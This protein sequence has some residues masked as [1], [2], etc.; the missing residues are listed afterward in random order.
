MR[1]D[2]RR[3][4]GGEVSLRRGFLRIGI[5]LVVLWLVFWT[6]TYVLHP[7]SS[8]TPEPASYAIRVTAWSVMDPCLVAAII[9]VGWAAAGFRP[10]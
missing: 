9:L 4:A 3:A 10:K 8:V 2:C 1:S 5:S 6:V 7:Y